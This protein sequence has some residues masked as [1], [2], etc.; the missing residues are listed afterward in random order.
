MRPAVGASNAEELIFSA[1]DA[2][3]LIATATLDGA[4]RSAT[5]QLLHGSECAYWPDLNLQLAALLQT[6]PDRDG[7]E[8][9]LE[10]TAQGFNQF[11]E[12]WRRAEAGETEW[13]P[14]FIPWFL[15]KG[16]RRK[17]DDFEMDTEERQF[18]ELHR[19]DA[20][21]MAWRRAK[22]NQLGN[23]ELFRQEYP[24]L[25]SEAFI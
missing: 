17:A 23:P 12:L 15:D 11:Y 6:V 24:S 10:S 5:A 16:Y 2:G 3:Y 9:L 21:Q 22:I 14:I 4:G 7:T 13:L 25:P 19:L 8:I 18:A 20:E 1:I